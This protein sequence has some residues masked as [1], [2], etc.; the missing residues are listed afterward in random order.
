MFI[1]CG[2]HIDAGVQATREMVV[3]APPI[4]IN[5]DLIDEKL[6]NILIS[7]APEQI[8]RV[9]SDLKSNNNSVGN[10][11]IKLLLHGQPGTGKSMLALA[12]ARVA[13]RECTVIHGSSIGNEY[14]HS[15]AQNIKRCFEEAI[16]KNTPQVIIIEEINNLVNHYNSDKQM[17]KNIVTELWLM[18]DKVENNP[19]ILVIGTANDIKKSPEQIKSRFGEYVV[20]I[21]KPDTDEKRRSILKYYLDFYDHSCG[22]NIL[23]KAVKKIDS[24]VPR[25]IKQVVTV[26]ASIARYRDNNKIVISSDDLDKAIKEVI[27]NGEQQ[28]DTPS[29][30]ERF[31]G[32]M[33]GVATPVT[34]VGNIVSTGHTGVTIYRSLQPSPVAAKKLVGFIITANRAVSIFR[35]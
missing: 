22:N 31:K 14:Q 1:F 4:S 19:N 8:K 26:A 11:S 18:L 23:I 30:W 34:V 21:H 35:R 7:Q 27:S 3:N 15:G 10:R 16:R 32:F 28:N 17:D 24:F 2:L 5:R 29:H 12:I 20:Q 6:A 13:N 9:L 25:Q 33:G